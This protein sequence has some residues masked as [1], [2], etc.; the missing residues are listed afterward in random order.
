M[1]R[2]DLDRPRD[3]GAIVSTAFSTWWQ[4]LGIFIALAAIPVFPAVFLI[5]GVWGGALS[6]PDANDVAATTT[7]TAVQTFVIAPLVTA[8]HVL[9]VMGLGRGEQP[10]F[11][12]ALRDGVR[13]LPVVVAAVL[14]YT[15]AVLL[16]I[17]AL[18]VPGIWLSVSLYFAAQAVVVDGTRAGKALRRSFDLVQGSWWRTFGILILLAILAAL[19][20]LPLGFVT[21]G[22]G[23]AAD[24]GPLFVLGSAVAQTVTLSFTALAGTLLFFDLRARKSAARAAAPPWTRPADTGLSTPER[25]Y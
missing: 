21:Q 8:M 15:L 23:L 11:G 5:D 22:V 10:S 20:A 9:V 12:G 2:L 6:D 4:H 13:V 1:N 14:L 25:P 16:G 3:A 18:I 7:S 24:N 17:V 19:L